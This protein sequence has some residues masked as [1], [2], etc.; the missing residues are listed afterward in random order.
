M[1]D[2]ATTDRPEL[3]AF[4]VLIRHRRIELGLTQETVASE[5]GVSQAGV[6]AW[7]TGVCY[8]AIPVMGR[9]A[10]RYGLDVGELMRVAALDAAEAVAR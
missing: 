5:L 4:A 1:T 8:P 10:L 9:L 3:G 7:E 2:Q 6:S